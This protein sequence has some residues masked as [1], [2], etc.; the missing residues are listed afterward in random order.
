MDKA[1]IIIAGLTALILSSKFE[2]GGLLNVISVV[3]VLSG[4]AAMYGMDR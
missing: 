4:L 1:L 2:L 3:V